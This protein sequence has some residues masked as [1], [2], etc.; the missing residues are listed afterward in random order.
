MC[1]RRRQKM[2]AWSKAEGTLNESGISTVKLR[3]AIKNYLQCPEDGHGRQ[4]RNRGTETQVHKQGRVQV[5]RRREVQ[6]WTWRARPK[7]GHHG[8]GVHARALSPLGHHHREDWRLTWRARPKQG[9][10]DT[11]AQAKVMC[12]RASVPRVSLSFLRYTALATRL[13][14]YLILVFFFTFTYFIHSSYYFST[15]SFYYLILCYP[16]TIDDCDM[17]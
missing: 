17:T 15:C 6:R 9:H 16:L 11:R 12:V 8:K 10:W 14:T 4:G 2:H 1:L 13:S 3:A 5:Y 7:Q